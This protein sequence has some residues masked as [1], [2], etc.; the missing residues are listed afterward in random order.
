MFRPFTLENSR[1]HTY[2]KLINFYFKELC[3]KEMAALVYNNYHAKNKIAT[4]TV[5][6]LLQILE[7][8][9]LSKISIT[10]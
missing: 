8:A 3:K 9:M 10:S 1:P 4:A 2:G 5:H 7:E 6:T